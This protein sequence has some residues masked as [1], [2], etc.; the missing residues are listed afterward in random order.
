MVFRRT[1]RESFIE[2]VEDLLR[3]EICD[4][5]GNWTAHYVRLRFLATDQSLIPNP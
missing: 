5:Y 3:E 4:S 1:E 2:E